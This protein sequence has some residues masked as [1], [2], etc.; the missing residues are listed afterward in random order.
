MSWSP[1]QQGQL[2]RQLL[3]CAPAQ[4]VPRL[5]SRVM[6]SKHRHR[7]AVLSGD[8]PRSAQNRHRRKRRHACV[9]KRSGTATRWWNCHSCGSNPP[10][11]HCSFTGSAGEQLPA[12]EQEHST[13]HP[14][15]LPVCSAAR[16]PASQGSP[17][18]SRVLPLQGSVPT[19][20]QIEFP[21]A[22]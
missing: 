19:E 14:L 3:P 9:S 8:R 21:V 15:S 6:V 20:S 16:P 13:G 11:C 17:S 22:P 4:H 10:S 5:C 7:S 12:A 1:A 18:T 2:D